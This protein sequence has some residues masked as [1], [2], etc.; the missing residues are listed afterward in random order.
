MVAAGG[1]GAAVKW[2]VRGRRPPAWPEASADS[3]PGP[4]PIRPVPVAIQ[5]PGDLADLVPDAELRRLLEQLVPSWFSF[6]TSRVLHAFRLW[7]PKATF[8]A[9][10]YRHPFE[11]RVFSGEELR[12]YLLD[13]RAFRRLV[14]AEVP[15]LVRTPYGVE[16]RSYPSGREAHFAGALGHADD[17]LVACAEVGL[18]TDAVLYAADPQAGPEGVSQATVGDIVRDTVARFTIRQELEWTTEA[19]ARYLAPRAGWANRFGEAFTFDQVATALLARP[20][21]QG[22]CLGTH[23]TYALT[24]LWRIGEQHPILSAQVRDRI[25]RYLR[26]VSL[27]VVAARLPAGHWG[28]HWATGRPAKAG[29]AE[30]DMVGAL[31]CTGHHLEWIALAPPDLRPPREQVRRAVRCVLRVAA[32]YNT[33]MRSEYYLDLTHL[34]RAL[35]LLKN[36]DPVEFVARAGKN[37]R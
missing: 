21:G 6:K 37:G 28:A 15:L 10:L 34:A 1:A 36:C 22:P 18:P 4:E 33:Y 30:A 2:T 32:G 24:C 12:A 5:P 13:H 11:F 26:D 9:S 19:L 23:V 3:A 8:P 35:C 29:A 31:A 20:R 7:G 16:A 17:L 27:M 25:A 14:P